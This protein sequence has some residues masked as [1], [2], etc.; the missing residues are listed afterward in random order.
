M[1]DKVLTCRDLQ[2][3]SVAEFVRGVWWARRR[4]FELPQGMAQDKP[5]SA[6]I[7]AFELR[8]PGNWHSRWLVQCPDCGGAEEA[9]PDEP[10]FFC[11]SCYNMAAGGRWRPVLY[12]RARARIEALLLARPDRRMR[13]WLPSESVADLEAQNIT[14]GAP[15][16]GRRGR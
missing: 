3:C 6:I 16:P 12:P 7:N 8:F 11:L 15:V 13:S 5:V 9:D 2:D 14:L 10:Q 1:G 4:T